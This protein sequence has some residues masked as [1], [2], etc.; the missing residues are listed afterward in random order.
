MAMLRDILVATGGL[1]RL[2]WKG[3]RKSRAGE[4]DRVAVHSNEG[5]R[6]EAVVVISRP[7]A[8]VFQAWKVFTGERSLTADLLA[9]SDIINEHENDVFAWS[10]R[11]DALI[12]NAGSV[13]FRTKEGTADSTELR[14]AIKFVAYPGHRIQGGIHQ[15]LLRFKMKL[16][17]GLHSG[18]NREVA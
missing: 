15:D 6:Y 11:S 9:M 17:S 7:L 12:P 13:H 5:E 18:L 3:L 8:E 10:S 14:L 16:E 1:A 4:K 2:F